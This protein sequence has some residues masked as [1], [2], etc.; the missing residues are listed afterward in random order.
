MHGHLNIKFVL[1][2]VSK[3]AGLGDVQH[4]NQQNE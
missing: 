4:M 1:L 2:V 3:E